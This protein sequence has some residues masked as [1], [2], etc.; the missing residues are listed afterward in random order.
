MKVFGMILLALLLLS[1]V[2][3][4]VRVVWNCG[5]LAIRF[6]AGPFRIALPKKKAKKQPKKP[7]AKKAVKINV[8]A[9][10]PKKNS[11]A[12]RL[13]LQAALAHWQELLALIGRTVRTPVLDRL[14]LHLTVGGTDAA[15]CAL[16]Y[17]R[18]C[19][20]VG[21]ILPVLENTFRIRR[22]DI[23]VQWDYAQQGLDCFVQAELTVRIYE[24]LA[25]AA[26]S[27]KLLLRLYQEIKMKQK[28]VQAT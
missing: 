17:G 15:A 21:G 20:A 9:E 13:W 3:V 25:L 18:V 8:E 19:A 28:A 24:M 10:K 27:L 23:Q 26:A 14:I 1:L 12:G 2:K 4:G 16:N 6:V 22:R 11:S 7:A 5:E